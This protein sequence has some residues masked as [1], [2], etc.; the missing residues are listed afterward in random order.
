MA[1]PTLNYSQK[2]PPMQTSIPGVQAIN[3]A[4]ILKGNLNVN[5][6]IELA[7]DA[8][9]SHVLPHIQRWNLSQA[10][11]PQ[12]PGSDISDSDSNLDRQL[13]SPAAS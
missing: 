3:S 9:Q 6:T 10:A 1:I 7:D 8:F 12:S 11:D 4:H 5:E 13:S 2:L